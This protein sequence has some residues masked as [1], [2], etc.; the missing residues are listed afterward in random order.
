MV[1]IVNDI[2]LIDHRTEA[3]YRF[4]TQVDPSLYP[5]VH[6][7]YEIVLVTGGLLQLTVS[8]RRFDLSAGEMALIRPGDVHAK[9][10]TDSSHINLAFPSGTVDA[11]FSYLCDADTRQ[12]LLEAEVLPPVRLGQPEFLVLLETMQQLNAIPAQDLAQ[13]RTA[14]R[15]ILFEVMTRWFLPGQRSP[16]F[17]RALPPWLAD[18]LALWQS[19]GHRSEGL[20]FFCRVSGR[21]K[22]HICRT[23]RRCFGMAPSAYLNRRRL[24]YAVNLLLHSDYSVTEVGYAAGFGSA[25]RFYHVFRSVYGIPPKKFLQECPASLMP[26]PFAPEAVD[27]GRRHAL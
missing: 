21:S 16:G 11:L 1:H 5:Q 3:H 6:D 22:E 4:H 24:D 10:G 12:R 14:L 15:E 2:Q 13:V 27:R 25:S 20:D 18:A 23:F 9:A 26:D 7:F 8:G 17:R 19:A